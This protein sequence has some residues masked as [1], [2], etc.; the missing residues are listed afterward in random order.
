M[1]ILP[2]IYILAVLNMIL[3]GDGSTHM[4][5]TDSHNV[6]KTF[7]FPATVFLL[8]PPYSANGKGFVFVQEALSQMTEGYAAILIQE[9]AGSGNGLPYTKNILKNNR[10][11]ASIHMPNDILR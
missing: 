9:N 10:L 7:D 1:E 11:I 4:Y 8:N 6:Y 5:E 3:M 2:N